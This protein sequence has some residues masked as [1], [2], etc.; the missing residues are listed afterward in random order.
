MPS[1]A[2]VLFAA[3]FLAFTGFSPATTTALA[4]PLQASTPAIPVNSPSSLVASR[5]VAKHIDTELVARFPTSPTVSTLQ[6]GSGNSTYLV[7]QLQVHHDKMKLNADKMH[8]YAA[9]KRAR[10]V[11]DAALQA[12]CTTEL[13]DFYNNFSGFYNILCLLNEI[14][15]CCPN[16]G[17]GKG[18]DC[19]DDSSVTEQLLKGVVDYTKVTLTATRTLVAGIPVLG[20]LLDPIVEDI[21]CIVD[22]LLDLT[23]DLV[24]CLINITNEL[25]RPLLASLSPLLTSLLGPLAPLVAPVL[26]LLGPECTKDKPCVL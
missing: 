24:D 13:T 7:H 18:L 9:Q 6:R 19:Y 16:V 3:S 1:I 2:R 10:S 17:V 11:D 26:A 20:P 12:G 25:L 14:A 21:K 23:E 22:S 5:I 8:K 15:V 4:S